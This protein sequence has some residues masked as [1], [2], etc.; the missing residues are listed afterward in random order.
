MSGVAQRAGQ[1]DIGAAAAV[2]RWEGTGRADYASG[3]SASPSATMSGQYGRSSTATNGSTHMAAFS[4]LRCSCRMG[5]ATWQ[6][7]A[8]R[9]DRRARE[10][11]REIPMELI[12]GHGT[13]AP[14]PAAGPSENRNP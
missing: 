11:N 1:V 2:S 7:A 9:D 13:I 6:A 3:I 5:L 14:S 8:D 4:G 12:I 10:L